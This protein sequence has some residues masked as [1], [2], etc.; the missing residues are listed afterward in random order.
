MTKFKNNQIF[1]DGFLS[2]ARPSECLVDW[3]SLLSGQT[4]S[5]MF[6]RNFF[7]LIWSNFH[8]ICWSTS[9]C[10]VQTY[11]ETFYNFCCCKLPCGGLWL[12]CVIKDITIMITIKQH[13]SITVRINIGMSAY[14]RGDTSYKLQPI[15]VHCLE[16]PRGNTMSHCT[17]GTLPTS[18][19][20]P[21][22]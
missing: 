21:F 16:K 6:T 22:H 13:S 20:L 12:C 5:G 19:Q 3:E 9:S 7:V 17:T 1:H 11:T 15:I 10:H 14:F 4:L 2:P 18:V 8:H